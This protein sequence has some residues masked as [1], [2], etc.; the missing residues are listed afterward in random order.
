METFA[1][2]PAAAGA[3]LF[4]ANVAIIDSNARHCGLM[5]GESVVCMTF[6]TISERFIDRSRGRPGAA[7]F[8]AWSHALC[9]R[10]QPWPRRRMLRP[11]APPEAPR[12]P[13]RDLRSRKS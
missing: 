2:I 10:P 5:A 1:L 9:W 8:T 11:A 7:S 6:D 12:A 4:D 3:K 13:P